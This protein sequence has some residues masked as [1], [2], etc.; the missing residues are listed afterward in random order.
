MVI[1]LSAIAITAVVSGLFHVIIFSST[2]L[3]GVSGIVFM[4]IVL[5][6]VAG[7]KE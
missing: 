4:M 7:M 5:S 2:V 3:L 1:S 6:S